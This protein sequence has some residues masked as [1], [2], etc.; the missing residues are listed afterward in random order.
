MPKNN[1]AFSPQPR[2]QR[3]DALPYIKNAEAILGLLKF[4]IYENNF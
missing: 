4:I 1:Y 2:L 3:I